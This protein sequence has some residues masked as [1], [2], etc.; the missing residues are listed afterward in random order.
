M[1]AGLGANS[2]NDDRPAPPPRLGRDICSTGHAGE[3]RDVQC[4]CPFEPALGKH[5]QLRFDACR[6]IQTTY[7]NED[8]VWEALQI[9]GEESSPAVGTEIPIEALA[10]L[11]HVVERLRPAADQREVIRWHAEEGGR[12]AT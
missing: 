8:R 10:G 1:G 11:R 6:L 2:G 5:L 4:I 7:R 3:L 9:A 12:F